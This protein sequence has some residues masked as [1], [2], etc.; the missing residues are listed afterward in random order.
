MTIYVHNIF[1]NK[2]I[3]D[4]FPILTLHLHV[5]NLLRTLD[6]P[7]AVPLQR[8][9]TVVLK[10]PARLHVPVHPRLD[11]DGR[12]PADRIR[13]LRRWRRRRMAVVV[14]RDVAIRGQF[15]RRG[16]N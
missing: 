9:T 16:R 10:L 14:L 8:G 3:S 6:R 13:A 4:F 15:G 1:K 2:N 12:R 11:A 5:G 7:Q